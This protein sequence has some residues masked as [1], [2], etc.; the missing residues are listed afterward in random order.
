MD[1]KSAFLNGKISEEVYV[2]QPPGFESSE[3]PNHVCILNKALY[4]LKQAPR[5]W[6]QANPKES[7]LVVVKRI[8]RCLKGIPNLSLWYPKGSGFDLKAYSDSDYAGCNLDRKS[9]SGRCQILGG[10]LVCYSAKK[11]TSVAMS[12]AEA[13]YVTAVGCCAQVLWIKSQLADYDVL[14]DKVPIFCD[15]TSAIAISNNPVLHSRT[16]HIDTS[17]H[18]YNDC[19]A[20]IGQTQNIYAAGAYNQGGNSY[21]P[22]GNRNLLSYRSNNYL[23]PPELNQNQNQ[24][25][26]NQK[27]QNQN[28]NQGNNHGNVQGNNQRRNQFFQRASHGQNPPPAYQAP[29]YQ[30]PGYQALVHQASIPQPDFLLEE[31]DAFLAIDDEPISSELDESYYDSEGDILILEEFLNDD[32]SSPPLPLQELK[33]VEPT[34]E[35]SSIDEPPMVNFKDLPPH[36]EYSFLVAVTF[37]L[38]QTSR[39]PANYDDMSVNRIDLIDVACEEYSQEVLG[40]SM[41]G[42]PTPSTKPIVSNSSP[43][44]TPFGDSDFLLEETDAFLAIDDEPISPKIDD[45][46]YDSDGDILLLGEFLMMI[47]HHHLF[48]HKN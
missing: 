23:G 24:N 43:T 21:Q 15:N 2:E 3:F 12:S 42:N 18:S 48:L 31:T 34:N 22:Q 29:A 30:A 19:P 28:R 35:K 40:F 25:N 47:H 27:Y 9:T 32:T 13:E 10:K 33:V 20:T 8:F 7:H 37:N 39:Y 46:Y 11:Q 16:K 44:L 36:L 5:A 26:Q 17:P 38:D 45:C 14:Y 6:Y 4:G 1:V 41:S